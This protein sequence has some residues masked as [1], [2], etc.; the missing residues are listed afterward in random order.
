MLKSSIAYVDDDMSNLELLKLILSEEFEVSTFNDP[1]KFLS[2]YS[3]SNYV[4]VILDLH[5]PKMTG[6]ALQEK[7]MDHP[8]FNG[9]PIIF[10]SSDDSD[11]ARIKSFTL[12]AVDF[13][14]RQISPTELLARVKSKIEFF[15]KHRSVI[16][17]GNLRVNLTLLKAFLNNKEVPLTFTE[18]KLLTQILKS[19]PELITKQQ[20]IDFVWNKGIVLDATLY[21]HVSNL[22]SKLE[23]WDHEIVGVKLKGIKLQ[24]RK[25]NEG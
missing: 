20:I 10:I 6:F 12:G 7:L 24:K 2:S 13:M 8:D 5:M 3:Q 23:S 19:Y 17:F 15:K 21:T 22:N 18:F 9:S 4:A 14:K 25:V 1:D 16:E 11:E